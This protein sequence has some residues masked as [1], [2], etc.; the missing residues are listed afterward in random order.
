VLDLRAENQLLKGVK[1]AADQPT[2]AYKQEW[3]AAK[4]RGIAKMTFAR[5]WAQALIDYAVEHGGMFPSSFDDA[6]VYFIAGAGDFPELTEV[7]SEQ[8]FEIVFRGRL[9][10]IADRETAMVLRERVPFANFRRPGYSRTYGMANGQA[11]IMSTDDGNFDVF[12]RKHQPVL[13]P[14][15]GGVG[16]GPE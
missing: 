5:A 6:R 14:E 13:K 15:S 12:E 8:D 4:Q 9:A 2:P 10:Q 11:L 16:S 3:E 7:P 1:R